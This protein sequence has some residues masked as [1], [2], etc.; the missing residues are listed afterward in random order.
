MLTAEQG[1]QFQA[2]GF[3]NGGKVIDDAQVETLRDE[4]TRVIDNY[5]SLQRKP[6]LLRNI[7]GNDAAVWQIVNIWEAS[8]AYADLMRS[9]KIAEEIA[10]LTDASTLRIWHDQIQ[11]KPAE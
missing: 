9:P 6:V 11:F 4:L 2:D 7:G 5:D 8:D 10:Q 1:A 3:L